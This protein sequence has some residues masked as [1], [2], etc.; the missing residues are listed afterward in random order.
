MKPKRKHFGSRSVQIFPNANCNRGTETLFAE[1]TKIII[2]W[3]LKYFLT[4]ST[5]VRMGVVVVLIIVMLIKL[6]LLIM[7]IVVMKLM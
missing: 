3:Q 5:S 7:V 4:V 1:N 2:C 6:I